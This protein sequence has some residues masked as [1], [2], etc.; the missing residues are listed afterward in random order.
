MNDTPLKP[1]IL[2]KLDGKI[3]SAHCTCVAGLSE[4]CSHVGAICF[5][6]NKINEARELVTNLN[7]ASYI[8]AND[9]FSEVSNRYSLQM[10]CA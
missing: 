3:I 4:S 1:W 6:V 7:F 8:T 5:A 10:E 9:I 2:T